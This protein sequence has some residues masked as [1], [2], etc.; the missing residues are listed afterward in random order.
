MFRILE[1]LKNGKHIDQYQTERVR[2]DGQIVQVSLTVSPIRDSSGRIVGG[3]A[4]SR[5]IT[6]RLENERRLACNL[7]ITR[8]LAE[9]PAVDDAITRVL[10]TICES[11]GWKLGAMWALDPHANVLDCQKTWRNGQGAESEFE[12]ICHQRPFSEGV[13]LPGRVWSS[14]KPAWI[15]DVTL[16]DNF[17]RATFATAEGLHAAFAKSIEEDTEHDIEYRIL[18]PNGEI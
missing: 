12:A 16:D 14:L 3:S 15:P 18:L 13:G 1:Y 8:I 11:L 9:S 5:D 4:I 10:Q 6:D 7:S 17:P 2:K